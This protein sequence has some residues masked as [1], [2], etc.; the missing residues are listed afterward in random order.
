MEQD[1]IREKLLKI[2][3]EKHFQGDNYHCYQ[4]KKKNWVVGYLNDYPLQ[5]GKGFEWVI[6]EE[7]AE[8]LVGRFEQQVKPTLAEIIKDMKFKIDTFLDDFLNHSDAHVSEYHKE[9]Y[10]IMAKNE[11]EIC[12]EI[13]AEYNEATAICNRFEQQVMPKTA[14]IEF[15]PN[16]DDIDEIVTDNCRLHLEYMDNDLIWMDI[17]LPN[18]DEYHVNIYHRNVKTKAWLKTSGE[19]VG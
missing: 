9:I 7:V 1:K 18:G 14:G 6:P 13:L 10:K 17:E 12:D 4:S 3:K 16:I 8:I 15:R 11:K 19:K 2:F 5:H